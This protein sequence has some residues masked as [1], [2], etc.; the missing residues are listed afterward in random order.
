MNQNTQTPPPEFDLYSAKNNA[1][2]VISFM[3]I[4]RRYATPLADAL[5][6]QA[7]PD[8]KDNVLKEPLWGESTIQDFLDERDTED[9][10]QKSA[11]YLLKKMHMQGASYIRF[12]TW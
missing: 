8:Y 12:V 5:D 7:E 1:F 6:K 2:T 4:D 3:D 10:I 9:E 11:E